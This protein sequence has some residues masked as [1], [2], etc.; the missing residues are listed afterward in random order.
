M[1]DDRGTAAR[2]ANA[3]RTSLKEGRMVA[4]E[5][6]VATGKARYSTSVDA[7]H[8][9]V[10]MHDREFLSAVIDQ[11]LQASGPYSIESSVAKSDGSFLWIGNQ[12]QVVRDA[13]G[14]PIR[15]TGIAADI[16]DRK[17]T[18]TGRLS[19][20]A[21]LKESRRLTQRIAETTPNVLFLYDVI[22]RRNVYA[23][24]RS[25]DVI[26]YTPKEIE[27]MGEKFITQLMHPDDVALLPKIARAYAVSADGEVFDHVFRFKHKNGQWRWIQCS[28]TIFSRTPDGRPKQILGS[29]TDIT[30]IKQTERE[31]QEL[32][33]RLLS[34][35]DEERRRIARE[36]HDVTGQNLTAI[37]L[38]LEILE[39]SVETSPAVKKLLT[40]SRQLCRESQNEIR[41]L[42][43]LLHPPELD[44]L[45]LVGA[46]SW[47][48]EGFWK[49]TGIN[50]LLD[51]R[52]DI[53]RLP[54]E[55]E[56]DLFRIVQEGLTN[57]MRHSGSETAII[58]LEKSESQFV[59][60]IEDSGRGLPKKML[61]ADEEPGSAFGVGIPGVRERL[62]QHGGS[63]EIRSTDQGT[64]L[65]CVVPLTSRRQ[66]IRRSKSG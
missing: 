36:L 50:V 54:R 59:L 35:Q 48:V 8:I 13:K 18:S 5:F 55:M 51:T 62:R 52:E 19:T 37:G 63:L 26:G 40:E 27:D 49:R 42:S 24:E 16:T 9:R 2:K 1:T 56:T 61:L 21:A 28:G 53:G 66:G 43:Y 4:W 6:E 47:Y 65:T 22:E 46:L 12:G 32:S 23:N 58:R 57:I 14:H 31:L 20:E 25:V 41:T 64:T 29:V 39:K 17:E 11:A 45:G 38:H 3:S 30:R 60:Q 7:E 34:A 10:L 15:V 44:V 33:A